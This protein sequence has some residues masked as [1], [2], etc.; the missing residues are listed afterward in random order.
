VGIAVV[1]AVLL[2]YTGTLTATPPPPEEAFPKI[3]FP[4]ASTDNT[5]V[6]VV[7]ADEDEFRFVNFKPLVPADGEVTVRPGLI[8]MGC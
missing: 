2:A 1:L 4:E 3:I 8:V 7:A 6:G 5:F